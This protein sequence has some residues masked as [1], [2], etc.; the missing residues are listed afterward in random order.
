ML[1]ATLKLRSQNTHKYYTK[2]NR[3]QCGWSRKVL[4]PYFRILSCSQFIVA[5][6]ISAFFFFARFVMLSLMDVVL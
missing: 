3:L 2:R 1:K 6:M 4:N 5:K